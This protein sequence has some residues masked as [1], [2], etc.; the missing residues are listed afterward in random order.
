VAT[1][2]PLT[3]FDDG[4][5]RIDFVEQK[6]T[7]DH[8]PLNLKPP[9]FR[10]LSVLAVRRG[11]IVTPEKLMEV[12]AGDSRFTPAEMNYAL[13]CLRTKLGQKECGE[14]I[15]TVRGFGYVYRSPSQGPSR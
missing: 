2:E 6:V 10:L 4:T 3:P 15:E 9:E 5:L 8:T 14:L 12:F 11:E 13:M 1:E 7:I